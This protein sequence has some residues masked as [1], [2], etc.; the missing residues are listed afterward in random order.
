METKLILEK[1]SVNLIRQ[2]IK[3]MKDFTR[4]ELEGVKHCIENDTNVTYKERVRGGF[5]D[6]IH[7]DSAICVYTMACC[8]LDNYSH[9]PTRSL[10]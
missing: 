8:L 9:N 2:F 7:N 3:E 4:E 6:V 10:A 1:T 5:K